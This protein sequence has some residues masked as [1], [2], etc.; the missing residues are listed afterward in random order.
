MR[1]VYHSASSYSSY[2]LHGYLELNAWLVRPR[3][4]FS[5]QNVD[6]IMWK[7]KI[8]VHSKLD[9]KIW[10]SFYRTFTFE[11]LKEFETKFYLTWRIHFKYF[12]MMTIEDILWKQITWNT[13]GWNWHRKLPGKPLFKQFFGRLFIRVCPCLLMLFLKLKQVY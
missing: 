9:S 5:G 10:F 7:Q 3:H 4:L 12:R 11:L 2:I 13:F 6:V 8:E 1:S